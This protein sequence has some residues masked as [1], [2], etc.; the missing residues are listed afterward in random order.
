M[1]GS[2]KACGRVLKSDDFL[3]GR[4]ED[5]LV[6]LR[7]RQLRVDVV[8]P[9]QKLDRHMKARRLR[10]GVHLPERNSPAYREFSILLQGEMEETKRHRKGKN[11]SL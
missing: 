3:V 8:A 4:L 9:D 7:Q 2:S 6:L 10:A 11:P 1:V 5:L